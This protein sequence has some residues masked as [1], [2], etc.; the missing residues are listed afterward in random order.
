LS[1]KYKGNFIDLAKQSNVLPIKRIIVAQN[2]ITTTN[3]ELLNIGRKM[4]VNYGYLTVSAKK[5]EVNNG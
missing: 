3:H 4:F 1:A 5:D 2:Q